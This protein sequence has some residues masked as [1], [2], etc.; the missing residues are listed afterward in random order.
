MTVWT[1]TGGVMVKIHSRWR[2]LCVC[3]WGRP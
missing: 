1:G 3:V 2:K